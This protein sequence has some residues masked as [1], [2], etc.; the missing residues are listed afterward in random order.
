M[1]IGGEITGTMSYQQDGKILHFTYKNDPTIDKNDP[2]IEVYD[3]LK[4]ETD[5][6]VTGE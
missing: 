5:I 6:T 2:A 3:V 1:T 4:R